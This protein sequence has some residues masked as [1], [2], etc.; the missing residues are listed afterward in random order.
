LSYSEEFVMSN[1][2]NSVD[3][4]GLLEIHSQRDGD[5]HVIALIGEF[6]LGGAASVDRALLDAEATDARQIE[7]D[8]TGLAFMDSTRNR[9]I[10]EAHLRSRAD[11]NRL[12]LTCGPGPVLRLFEMTA[13][14]D[15][16]PF[17]PP[18]I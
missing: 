9:L 13:M 5:R 10:H 8:L 3:E 7:L 12:V 1:V 16:L 14:I 2:S 18:T 15:R 6:D 11:G 4:F 17:T